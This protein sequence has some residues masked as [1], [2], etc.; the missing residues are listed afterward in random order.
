MVGSEGSNVEPVEDLILR[1][2]LL[3]AFSVLSQL[4]KDDVDSNGSDYDHNSH[5]DVDSAPISSAVNCAHVAEETDVKQ[6]PTSLIEVE[7]LG[8]LD[9][10]RSRRER[11]RLL[12]VDGLLN[13]YSKGILRPSVEEIGI[14]AGVSVRSIFRYFNDI[15]DLVRSAIA[16]AIYRALPFLEICV[17]ADATLYERVGA[18]ID[19]RI[20]LFSAI[21]P[22][23][24]VARLNA[25]F[26][27]ILQEELAKNR[28]FLRRQIVSV[29][30]EFLPICESGDLNTTLTAIDILCS[31]EAYTL[32]SN[33]RIIPKDQ[34]KTC[35]SDSIIGIIHRGKYRLK[36]LDEQSRLCRTKE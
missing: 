20:S 13:L 34:I 24:I 19:Q 36:G 6:S 30:G 7:L 10:R 4:P 1:G 5:L 14:E 17:S 35:L 3:E 28:I 21:A 32:M 27:P 33:D 9:G 22:V 26:Q 8:D 12:V 16:R 2:T 11:N 15:D 29:L 23:A 31:F 18:L 25:P